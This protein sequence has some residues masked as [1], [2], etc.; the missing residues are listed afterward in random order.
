MINELLDSEPGDVADEAVRGFARGFLI[1]AP[2]MSR[3]PKRPR[4]SEPGPADPEPA[5]PKPAEPKPDGA[6]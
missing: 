6:A 5:E 4:A 3:A 2:R 1:G